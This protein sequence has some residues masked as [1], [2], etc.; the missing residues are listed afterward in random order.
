MKANQ[1]NRAILVGHNA[2]FD[3]G[4]LTAATERLGL[5]RNPFHPFSYFDTATLAGLAVGHTVLAR[6]CALAD[7]PFDNKEAHSAQYDV[8]KTAELF[9]L[10]VNRWRSLGGWSPTAQAAAL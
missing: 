2:H 3:A 8:T 4:F 7:I 9:C 1:C 6:A 5:K 10:I